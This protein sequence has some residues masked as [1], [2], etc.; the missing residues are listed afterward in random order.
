[1]A[2]RL[3]GTAVTDSNGEATITYTGTGAGKLNVVAE[4]GTFVSEIYELWDTLFYD[5][6]T[7]SDT[8]NNTGWT[9]YRG[10]LSFDNAT[11]IEIATGETNTIYTR[12]FTLGDGLAIEFDLNVNFSSSQIFRLCNDWSTVGSAT[13]SSLNL[14]D[15]SWAHIKIV[16]QN[17]AGLI[18]RSINDTNPI[19]F[20]YTA[21]TR[22]YF[23]IENADDSLK[24]KNFKIYPI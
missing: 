8:K 9:N 14:S 13:K 6:A 20:N 4:S 3:I 2:R 17:G 24:Y 1:M 10:T 16:L 15:N 7:S 18:Y 21:L 22:F 12:T 11:K 19:S 23:F 5:E